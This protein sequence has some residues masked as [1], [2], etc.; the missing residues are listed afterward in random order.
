M[1]TDLILDCWIN[2]KPFRI[3]GIFVASQSTNTDR[4][5]SAPIEFTVCQQAHISGDLGALKLLLQTSVK[6]NSKTIFVTF[7]YWIR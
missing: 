1:H 7:T 6:T 4:R 3:I 2:R 5:I